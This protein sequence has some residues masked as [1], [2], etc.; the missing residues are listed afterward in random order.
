MTYKSL[1]GGIMVI[2]QL[3]LKLGTK[4]LCLV[5]VIVLLFSVSIGTVMLKEI[6]DSMKQMATEKAKGDLALSSAYIDDVISGDWQIKTISFI[7]VK[8]KSTKMRISLICL[9][10]NR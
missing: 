7:K 6:T 10:K 8:H 4:I 2:K 9:A 3:K 5:F 1:K